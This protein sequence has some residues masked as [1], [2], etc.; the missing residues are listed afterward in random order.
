M[1]KLLTV[2][3]SKFYMLRVNYPKA[4]EISVDRDNTVEES[5]DPLAEK[6]PAAEETI[7]STK[8]V[9]GAIDLD[10]TEENKKL[11]SD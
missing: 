8:S 9:E 10:E 3:K 6:K 2:T 7:N 1:K 11:R 4:F 5:Y